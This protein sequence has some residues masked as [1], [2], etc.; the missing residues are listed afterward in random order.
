MRNVLERYLIG[1]KSLSV[2]PADKAVFIETDAGP[3]LNGILDNQI[4]IYN[5]DTGVSVGPGVTVTTVPRLVI[6][7]G[8]DTDG[9]GI[10]NVLRKSAYDF[11][12]G[13]GLNAVTAEGPECGQ[14]KILDVGIGC[15]ERGKP[16]SLIIEART[17]HTENF[18]K[19][20]DFERWTQTVEFDFDD[21]AG[22]DQPL[23][24]KEIACALANKFN[25]K[26]RNYSL[27]KN[28]SLIKKVR[29]H[30]DKDRPFHVYVLHPNDYQFCFT[31]ASA[32]CVGCNTIDA[33]TGITI[34]TGVGAV[35]TNFQL[36]T[37]PADATKTKVGQVQRILKQINGLLGDRG[38]ALDASTFTGNA[39]PCCDGV[40]ILINACVPIQLLGDGGD[41]ITPCDTGLPT[42]NVIKY[43]ECG[44]CSGS[45][46][47]TFCSFLRI[48]P[49]PIELEKFCDTPDNYQKTLYTDIRVT[50]SYNNNNIGKF[51]VFELQPWKLPKN[52]AYQALHK[53]ALQDTSANA[54]FSYG[55]DEFVG[56]YH[57]LLKGSRTK[58]MLHG[59]LAGCD[60]LDGL[61]VYNIHHT[62]FKKETSVFGT[63]QRP[64]V[65]TTVL[66]PS[67]NTAART[68]F[69]A[70]L[71]PW[72]VSA[73]GENNTIYKTVTCAVDQDQ[74]ERILDA[75]YEVT[76]AEYPNANGKVL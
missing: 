48:V 49:K 16:I 36:T 62:G 57:N 37:D 18:Y 47:E 14:V 23:D 2:Y 15:M 24:C 21:C 76:T 60:S 53:V 35:T 40:K 63:A 22:C 25:G 6:A 50:T 38:Y 55:Y 51:K 73:R 10:A 31:T 56:K 44:A 58:E 52:L 20:N 46:T 71:N 42:H 32:A 68:E 59:L 17:G 41:P 54:P 61:C 45:T 39:K 28:I 67:T 12:D 72:I 5:A 9:D 29:A 4:V 65:R 33:I 3:A 69:E 7:Q 64:R 70:I 1:A 11:I 30:Q 27:T 66:I 74:I 26:D 8:I 19:Y 75:D 34:G 43:G 13:A